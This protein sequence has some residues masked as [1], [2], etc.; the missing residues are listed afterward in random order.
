ML[1]E[2]STKLD[3]I[4]AVNLNQAMLEL[5]VVVPLENKL[6]LEL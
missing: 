4:S 2:K 6:L 3:S 1:V 5:L